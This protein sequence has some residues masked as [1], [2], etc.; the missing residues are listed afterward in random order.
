MQRHDGGE[1]EINEIAPEVIVASQRGHVR[2]KRELI[3]MR[4]GVQEPKDTGRAKPTT[5]EKINWWLERRAQM[6]SK[7]AWA[8][9]GRKY[10]RFMFW[11]SLSDVLIMQNIVKHVTK[12]M[13]FPK[14][15]VG[16]FR[17]MLLQ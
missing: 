16:K 10:G 11:L 2:R 12:I 4:R 7:I 8:E 15:L 14:R 13:L 5:A 9:Y 3:Y 6:K 1:I 17:R